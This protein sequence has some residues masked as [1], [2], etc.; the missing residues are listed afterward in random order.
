MVLLIMFKP[1]INKY[2]LRVCSTYIG[3]TISDTEK[4]VLKPD[5]P[6]SFLFANLI[7][8][9]G[10]LL[11]NIFKLNVMCMHTDGILLVDSKRSTARGW[12]KEWVTFDGKY[13]KYF[14]NDKV[15]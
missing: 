7:C 14:S 9:L 2:L 4:F 3:V 8:C 12:A 6:H 5:K 1:R 15:G 11:V 10:G 13:L